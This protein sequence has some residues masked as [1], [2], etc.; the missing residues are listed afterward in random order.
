MLGGTYRDAAASGLSEENEEEELGLPSSSPRTSSAEACSRGRSAFG[1]GEDVLSR[2]PGNG[3]IRSL[4]TAD[5]DDEFALNIPFVASKGSASHIGLGAFAS[6]GP[7]TSSHVESRPHQQ[8]TPAATAE[9]RSS[10]SDRE[11]GERQLSIAGKWEKAESALLNKYQG[12]DILDDSD[13]RQD[14]EEF[15]AWKARDA[16]RRQQLQL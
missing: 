13:R 5:A 14:E 15:R 4:R 2:I 7:S 6:T 8:R 10:V 9:T 16:F 12:S 11:Q 3:A 1:S